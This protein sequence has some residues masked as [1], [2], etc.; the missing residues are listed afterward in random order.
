MH[1]GSLKSIG[2]AKVTYCVSKMSADT[3][4]YNDN[5]LGGLCQWKHQF[6]FR[7]LASGQYLAVETSSSPSQNQSSSSNNNN[8]NLPPLDHNSQQQQ[9]QPFKTLQLCKSKQATANTVFVLKPTS[10]LVCS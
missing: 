4:K 3:I 8:R 6:R 2:Q 7:H 5:G 1:Y 10:A 9:Q